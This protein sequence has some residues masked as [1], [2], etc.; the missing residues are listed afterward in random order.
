MKRS[1]VK[2]VQSVKGADVLLVKAAG[3]F[4]DIAKCESLATPQHAT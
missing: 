1:G 2:E 3:R 4:S